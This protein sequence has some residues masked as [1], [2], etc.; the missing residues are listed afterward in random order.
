MELSDNT[1]KVMENDVSA[2]LNNELSRVLD[3]VSGNTISNSTNRDN[4]TSHD[5]ATSQDNVTKSVPRDTPDARPSPQSPSEV[6]AN[7]IVRK[8]GDG[9]NPP[10]K[11]PTGRDQT[12]YN[13][14]EGKRRVIIFNQQTFAPRLKLNPRKGT[15]VDVRSITA[16]FKALDWEIQLYNDST[17]AKIRD[18]ILRQVQLCD[19]EIA[20][21]AIF[22][23]SHGEDNGTIF[24][25]DYPFRVDH[26]ILF[27]LAADKSPSLAGKPKLV[28]VQACQGQETDQGTSVMEGR[29]R[30][31]TSQ[32]STSTYKI[33]NYSDFLI[34]Q[35]SFWDHFSFRSSETGSWFIQALCNK[36]DHSGEEEA[37]FDILLTVSHSVA[38]EKESNV[39][40]K[41]HLDKKKQ[42]P[43]LY[44]TML[45]KMFLKGSSTSQSPVETVSVTSISDTSSVKE[46]T[47]LAQAVSELKVEAREKTGST[48]SLNKL[49]K[50]SKSKEKDCKMM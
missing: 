6:D 46:T 17:V 15:E 16:T 2:S 24:A 50:G 45:R 35:A 25:A 9:Q 8:G 36:I 47:A 27:Q 30:R 12:S 4:V 11:I 22:I 5:S 23:L 14:T 34:F 40:G 44:S 10:F 18:I 43:L 1:N 33:P 48:R 20:A 42:V 13:L 37:L 49:M 7:P 32:D 3:R 21:L 28:F 38:V 26:D 41:P 39:P 29:R 31:H 19:D